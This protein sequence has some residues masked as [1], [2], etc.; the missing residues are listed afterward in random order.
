MKKESKKIV[1]WTVVVLILVL[2]FIVVK[3][4]DGFIE[5]FKAV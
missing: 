3:N 5:G 1:G 4:W 2:L